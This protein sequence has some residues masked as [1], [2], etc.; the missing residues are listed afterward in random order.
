MN[1]E[2][3]IGSHDWRR[4]CP[5]EQKLNV[6]WFVFSYTLLITCT[7]NSMSTVQLSNKPSVQSQCGI[8]QQQQKKPLWKQNTGV[9]FSC[10]RGEKALTV[11]LNPT[12]AHLLC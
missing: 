11:P 6:L 5:Y 3:C 9:D 2:V 10:L 7:E 1:Y 4:V 12:Q 8:Q